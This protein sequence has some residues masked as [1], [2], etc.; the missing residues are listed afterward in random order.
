MILTKYNVPQEKTQSL[1]LSDALKVSSK[2]KNPEVL[3]SWYSKIFNI[4]KSHFL[5]SQTFSNI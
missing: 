4:Q 1:R 3:R 2:Q 5:H